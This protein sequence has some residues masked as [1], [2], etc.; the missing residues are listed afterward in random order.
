MGVLVV[1]LFTREWIEIDKTLSIFNSG[2]SPSLRGSGLKSKPKPE[3]TVV[4]SLPLYEGVDWNCG[5]TIDSL[6]RN[7]VSLFTREW[8]EII[9]RN[10]WL[11]AWKSPSLRG[12]GLKSFPYSKRFITIASVS[13][14]TR[15]WIE[16]WALS[17]SLAVACC[18]PLYEGVD[19]NPQSVRILSQLQRSPSLRGSGLKFVVAFSS[20]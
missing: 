9:W 20:F 3:S 5:K 19:W 14:F 4:T 13:L 15:E 7:V 2:E 18:L 6:K 16:I 11:R 8:I 12:S 10:I 1:S 17:E